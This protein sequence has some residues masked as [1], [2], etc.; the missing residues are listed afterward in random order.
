MKD[1]LKARIHEDVDHVEEISGASLVLNVVELSVLLFLVITACVKSFSAL[2]RS[3]TAQ[4]TLPAISVSNPAPLLGSTANQ[5]VSSSVPFSPPPVN[6]AVTP[7]RNNGAASTPSY[8]PGFVGGAAP[9]AS[10]NHG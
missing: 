10:F 9:N 8:P 2:Q 7:I 6:V 1:H 4:P 3:R 5:N